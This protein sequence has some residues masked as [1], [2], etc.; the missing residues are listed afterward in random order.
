MSDQDAL[1]DQLTVAFEELADRAQPD[2]GERQQDF[3]FHMLDWKDDLRN[4]ATLYSEPERFTAAQA[5]SIV[6]AFLYHAVSHAV[7]AARLTNHFLDAFKGEH[8]RE[9]SQEK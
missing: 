6:Q 9:E 1:K 5:S 8:A 3:V 4:L 7:A 2:F